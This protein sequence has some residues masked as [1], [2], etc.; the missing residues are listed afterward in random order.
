MTL[1]KTGEIFYGFYLHFSDEDFD[2]TGKQY[3]V[4]GYLKSKLERYI[5]HNQYTLE[6]YMSYNEQTIK[7][8][9]ILNQLKY[10]SGYDIET[11]MSNDDTRWF[12][13][14]LKY[15]V[16][17]FTK[18][19]ETAMVCE[20]VFDLYRLRLTGKIHFYSFVYIIVLLDLKDIKSNPAIVAEF[21]WG[22]R[23][24]KV[25]KFDVG[26]FKESLEPMRKKVEM[27]W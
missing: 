11:K 3:T 22:A 19:V 27:V 8:Y 20:N 23:A 21:K 2:F 10:R 18:D 9:A 1:Y 13:R 7:L 12:A 4:P 24:C 6:K 25:F 5:K 14:I 16:H 17:D 26:S 15:H